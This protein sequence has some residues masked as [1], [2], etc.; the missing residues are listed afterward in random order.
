MIYVYSHLKYSTYSITFIKRTTCDNFSAYVRS[1][2]V[3]L[4][5]LYQSVLEENIS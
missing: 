1:V 5:A 2:V 3:T 4:V